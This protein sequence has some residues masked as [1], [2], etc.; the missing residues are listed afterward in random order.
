MSN[1]EKISKNFLKEWLNWQ[2]MGLGLRILAFSLRR[3]GKKDRW[4]ARALKELNGV[5]CF[6]SHR[7]NFSCYL[8]FGSGTVKFYPRWSGSVNFT[9]TFFQPAIFE[10]GF[11]SGN[12][13]KVVIENKLS[14]S[15]D[16]YYLYQFGFLMSLL[17][18]SFRKDKS[19][20]GRNFESTS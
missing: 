8:V 14:Q 1:P 9:F 17:E 19:G 2:A 15:G 10:M 6:E 7:G 5:Y 11:K 3:Q 12:P 4:L 16:L 20:I 18:R 13:L